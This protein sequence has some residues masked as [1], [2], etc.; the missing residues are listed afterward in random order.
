MGA[1]LSK[2]VAYIHAKID[3]A[4]QAVRTRIS[5]AKNYVC[6]SINDTKLAIKSSVVDT[7]NSISTSIHSKIDNTKTAIFTRVDNTKKACRNTTNCIKLSIQNRVNAV[8]DGISTITNSVRLG[9]WAVATSVASVGGAVKNGAVAVKSSF[10]GTF[11]RTRTRVNE[12]SERTS[13]HKLSGFKKVKYAIFV[14]I[15]LLVV[16]I[17]GVLLWDVYNGDMDAAQRK[18]HAMYSF[19]YSTSVVSGKVL[20]RLCTTCLSCASSGLQIASGYILVW[21]QNALTHLM[22]AAN[23]T[24]VYSVEA[25]K[26]GFKHTVIASQT[27]GHFLNES[28][29]VS[30]EYISAGSKVTW[31]YFLLACARTWIFVMYAFERCAE[32]AVIATEFTISALHVALL[33]LARTLKTCTTYLLNA[34]ELILK[35]L[36]HATTAGIALAVDCSIDAAVWS[37][38]MLKYAAT[39][40]R[41]KL[42]AN[43]QVLSYDLYTGSYTISE[44]LLDTSSY[45]LHK[46]VRGTVAFVHWTTYALY[47]GSDWLLQSAKVTTAAV[48]TGTVVVY[49]STYDATITSYGAI[50]EALTWT[51]D[52]VT[53]VSYT[54]YVYTYSVL[55][56]GY[57]VVYVVS[58]FVYTQTDAIVRFTAYWVTTIAVFLWQLLSVIVMTIS[59]VLDVALN[60]IGVKYLVIVSQFIMKWS[61]ILGEIVFA[62]LSEVGTYLGRFFYT[63]GIYLYNVSYIVCAFLWQLVAGVMGVVKIFVG[64]LVYC[65][66]AVFQVALWFVEEIVLAYG[67]MLAQYNFYR[68]TLFFG[69]TILLSLYCSGLMQDRT[70]VD[71]DN[72]DG[73]CDDGGHGDASRGLEG[74]STDEMVVEESHYKSDATTVHEMKVKSLEARSPPAYV[75]QSVIPAYDEI[76]DIEDDE[77]IAIGDHLS[78]DTDDESDFELADI[79]D[80]MESSSSEGDLEPNRVEELT[81]PEIGHQ[82]NH[83][84]FPPN[85]PIVV[86]EVLTGAMVLPYT[87]DV[88]ANLCDNLMESDNDTCGRDL[89]QEEAHEGDEFAD[90]E[91]L[92]DFPDLDGD[93][94]EGEGALG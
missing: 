3:Q 90:I 67:Y 85:D 25:A 70:M 54:T 80:V 81:L 68:E 65:V 91:E 86:E 13:Q 23:A 79:P 94:E 75:Q 60:R 44:L 1:I 92:G 18:I 71:T 59:H 64:A 52:T 74:L 84:D 62:F 82:P 20:L 37:V 4:K 76:D 61:L 41:V 36:L 11:S 40:G 19:A 89:Q 87:D 45:V 33:C 46:T 63:T 2:P 55:S 29:Y 10:S 26:V 93:E 42:W 66:T 53:T 69:F 83:S 56:T 88:A 57:H 6:T 30:A 15:A 24:Q 8:A 58:T 9:G 22:F 31:E 12:D 72:V 27:A 78:E 17:G 5:N 7:K 14:W 21:S 47:T 51:F 38:E 32:F 49:H 73:D 35:Y 34:T 16:V 77:D 43:L 50:C 48:A 28:A 39:D